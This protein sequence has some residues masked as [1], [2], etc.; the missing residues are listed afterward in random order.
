MLQG[1]GD[2]WRVVGITGKRPP[3]RPVSVLRLGLGAA[4]TSPTPWWA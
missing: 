1:P 2:A 3:E 4:H